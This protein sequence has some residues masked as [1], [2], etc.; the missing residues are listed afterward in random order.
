[1]AINPAP[2]INNLD[3]IKQWYYKAADLAIMQIA[4]TPWSACGRKIAWIAA[5]WWPSTDSNRC[6]PG[7]REELHRAHCARVVDLTAGTALDNDLVSGQRA[8]QRGP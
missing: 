2:A 3:V 1:M 7:A 6:H 4:P 5:S 8:I